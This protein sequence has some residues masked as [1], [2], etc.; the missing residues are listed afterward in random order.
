MEVCL[1]AHGIKDRL[2]ELNFNNTLSIFFHNAH[3]FLFREETRFFQIW[4]Q[5]LLKDFNEQFWDAIASHDIEPQCVCVCTTS[6]T[7]IH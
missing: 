3:S 6:E 4:L 1:L 5:N 2:F 7:E